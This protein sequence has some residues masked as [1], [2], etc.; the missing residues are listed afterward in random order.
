[1]AHACAE[2]LAAGG[3][4]TAAICISKGPDVSEVGATSC[5]S[6]FWESL[7]GLTPVERGGSYANSAGQS[8]KASAS[9]G[10]G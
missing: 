10:R 4:W 3:T 7:P 6:D 5:I 8:S 2:L 9:G 1:M